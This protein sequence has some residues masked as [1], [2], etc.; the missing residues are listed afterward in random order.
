MSVIG[1]SC[2]LPSER[3]EGCACAA[4]TEPAGGKAAGTAV[5][6]AVVAAAC[7]ACCVLPFTLP[8]VVLASAGSVITVLDHAHGLM[9]GL[10]IAVV[11]CAWGWIV[12]RSRRT[13]LKIRPSV[14][15][16]MCAATVLTATAALWPIMEYAVFHALGAAK[17]PKV[18]A[19]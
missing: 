13:G 12:W 11:L 6:T 16:A 17:K 1:P 5:A 2:S 10:S 7:T 18:P 15:A 19:N 9:T 14:L 4:K 8:A 3:S